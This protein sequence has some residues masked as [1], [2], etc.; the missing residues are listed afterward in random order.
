MCGETR[1]DGLYEVTCARV[2]WLSCGAGRVSTHTHKQTVQ[3][4]EPIRVLEQDTTARL[5]LSVTTSVYRPYSRWTRISNIKYS[6]QFHT[7]NDT[8]KNS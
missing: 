7:N 3:Y 1:P 2:F 4:V 5:L 6:T 8:A